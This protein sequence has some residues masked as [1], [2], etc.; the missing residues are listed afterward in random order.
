M[1]TTNTIQQ[2]NSDLAEKLNEEALSNPHSPNVGKFAGIAN[3]KLIVVADNWDAVIDNLEQ[4]ESDPAKTL[5]IEL[6]LDY[7]TPQDIWGVD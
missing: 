6:G 2:L 1:S 4:V 5:C 3:G 7:K